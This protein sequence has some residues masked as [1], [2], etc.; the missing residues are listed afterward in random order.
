MSAGSGE[1][2]G[3]GF[4]TVLETYDDV[5]GR[6]ARHEQ[7]GDGTEIGSFRPSTGLVSIIILCH[8]QLDYTAQCVE[9]IFKH[10]P[11]EIELIFVDNASTDRTP[12]YLSSLSATHNNVHVITNK[13]NLGFA[14]AVNQGIRRAA[15]DYVLLLNNDVLVTEG[16]LARMLACANRDD[17]I[18]LVGP[19]SNY[20]AGIQRVV[21]PGYSVANLDEYAAEHFRKYAGSVQRTARVIG[22]CMLIKRAVID[23]IG[24]FDVTFGIGNFEDDDFC[25]RAG[26]AG[27]YVFIAQDVFIHH[28][29]SATFRGANLDYTKLMQ[30]N[31]WRFEK[32]WNIKIGNNGYNPLTVLVRPF[33]PVLHYF[34]LVSEWSA[35]ALLVEAV[36]LFGLSKV[37]ESYAT[38]VRALELEPDNRDGWHNMALIAMSQ[39]DFAAAL[40]WWRRFPETEMDA[41]RL[42]LAGICYFQTG[43]L[44]EAVTCF[45][46]VLEMDPT[47][48]DARENLD[49]AFKAA[50]GLAPAGGARIVH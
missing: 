32:K 38:L 16:W 12:E 37:V 15:G 34:P 28:Y 17:R 43:N 20:V 1:P 39:G 44:S 10:T 27:F 30:Q 41:E 21:D 31:A 9:S 50:N 5:P 35:H 3:S 14:A 4:R 24:G 42:N 18:G 48:P 8:N 33:D 26:V 11:E 49:I 45:Q 47:Y 7:L 22:F 6:E 25:L 29:G 2:R 19:V 13:K 46:R 36:R 23:K 40:E